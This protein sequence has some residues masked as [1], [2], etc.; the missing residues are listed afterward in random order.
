M[1]ETVP[2]KLKYRFLIHV[3]KVTIFPLFS[4][5]EAICSET[6]VVYMPFFAEQPKSALIAKQL[7]FAEYLN[8]MTFDTQNIIEKMTAVLDNEKYHKNIVRI[9]SLFVD[10]IMDQLD[11]GVFWTEKV[12]RYGKRPIFFKRFGM[13]LQWIQFLYLDV[14]ALVFGAIFI[15]AHK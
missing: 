11:E 1:G 6:P 15:V 8:K 4:V 13:R 3:I 9:K 5:K 14:I 12:I 10:R 2:A 7:G